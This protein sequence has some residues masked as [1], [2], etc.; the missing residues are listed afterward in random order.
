MGLAGDGGVGLGPK[1]S[2]GSTSAAH[3]KQSK[4]TAGVTLTEQCLRWELGWNPE[5]Q[6]ES[7]LNRNGWRATEPQAGRNLEIAADAQTDRDRRLLVFLSCTL[8]SL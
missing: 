3:M 7:E 2:T 8:L 1:V 6:T 5:L 4:P